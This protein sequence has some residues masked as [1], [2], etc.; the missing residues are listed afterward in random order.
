M[1]AK[2]LSGKEIGQK[3]RE[4]L[5]REIEET[6]PKDGPRPR[7]AVVLVGDD[8]ASHVYV[9][10][11]EKACEKV[12][13]ETEDY[14]PPADMPQEELVALVDKLNADPA[15]NGVLVQLPLPDH[16]DEAFILE[17]ILPAKDV[18]GF[19]PY[20]LGQLVL[21]K[22]VLAP[23]T[24]S[25]VMAMLDSAGIEVQGKNVAMVGRS[26]IVGKPLAAMFTNKSA[27]VTICH[28]KTRDLKEECRRS[29][30]VI[31]AIGRA[32]MINADYVSEGA[33]VIDVGINRVDDKLVGDVDFDAVIDKVSAITPVPG[34]VGPMTI[35]MLLHNTLKAFRFQT[36]ESDHGSALR[37]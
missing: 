7:L 5:Q 23:A 20:N 12:G 26:R 11:K 19:H 10:N 8:P 32:R 29:D 4:N 17:R 31:A 28:S 2:I 24:P 16:M 35:T 30:I 6:I 14:K 37:T 33:V 25:G 36:Q 1:P 9:R 34:G 3:I 13:I 21:G 15:V 18:D 27:T 22:D